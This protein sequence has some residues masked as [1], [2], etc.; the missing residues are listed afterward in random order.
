MA[1]KDQYNKDED[2]TEDEEEELDEGVRLVTHCA[3]DLP[4]T[5]H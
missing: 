5:L 3:D 2:E 4:L 1:D